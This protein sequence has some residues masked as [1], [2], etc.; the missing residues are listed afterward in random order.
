[1]RR[2]SLRIS[3]RASGTRTNWKGPLRR[4]FL[5]GGPIATQIYVTHR[6]SRGLDPRVTLNA[7]QSA[8]DPRVK[9]EGTPGGAGRT[10]V[11]GRKVKAVNNA[12]AAAPS[13]GPR[14]ARPIAPAAPPVRAC[15]LAGRSAA[16]AR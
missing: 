15:A 9:P 6:R 5:F 10:V 1:M 8:I 3:S 13:P 4:A 16:I 2:R 11:R 7:A 14:Y 12:A